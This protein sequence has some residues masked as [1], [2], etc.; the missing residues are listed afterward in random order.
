M[1]G[2]SLARAEVASDGAI[3]DDHGLAT[4]DLNIY[5]SVRAHYR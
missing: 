5:P 3:S 1:N 4:E 2:D